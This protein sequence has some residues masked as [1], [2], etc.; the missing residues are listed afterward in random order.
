MKIFR[1][2]VV[3]MVTF[4]MTACSDYLD[5]KPYG[6]VVPTTPEEFSA[7]LNSHLDAIDRGTCGLSCAEVFSCI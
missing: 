5:I 6:K 3:A 7:L 4:A 2:L 1:I